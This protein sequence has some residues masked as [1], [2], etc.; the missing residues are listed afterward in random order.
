LQGIY[1]YGDYCSGRIWGLR[2]G[3]AGWENRLLIDAPFWITSFGTDES[4]GLWVA[5]YNSSPQGAVYQI[6][7]ARGVAYLPVLRKP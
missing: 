5:A 1:L 2:K 6:V 4:G 7:E 3:A